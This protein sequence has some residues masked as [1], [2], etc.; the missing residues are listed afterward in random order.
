V[1]CPLFSG[2]ELSATLSSRH[3]RAQSPRGRP[4]N[5]VCVPAGTSA[6]LPG[7]FPGPE[8][9]YWAVAHT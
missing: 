2:R 4:R 5:C 1:H 9:N 8:S 3:E 6:Q 7:R